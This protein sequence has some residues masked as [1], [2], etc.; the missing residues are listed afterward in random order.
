MEDVGDL[1][2]RPLDDFE[3]EA[4][5]KIR[6]GEEVVT[7]ATLN[8]IQMVGAVRALSTC[9]HCHGGNEG[10]LLGAFSYEILR[11]PPIESLGGE[12]N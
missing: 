9:I 11:N 4:L 12:M 2:K 7:Q 1:P 10:D 8:R 5:E 3:A 6:T